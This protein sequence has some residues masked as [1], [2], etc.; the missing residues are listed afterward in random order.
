MLAV[1]AL[2]GCQADVDVGLDVEPDGSGQ[3]KATVRL[4]RAAAAQVPNL[5]GQ[6][7]VE[8][9]A[10]AGWRL[11]G[12]TRSDDGGAQVSAVKSFDSPAGAR[13]AVEE[14]AGP[15]GPLRDFAL[16]LRR[17]FLETRTE[18][19]GTVDLSS[20]LEGFG[21]EVLRNRLGGSSLGV[22]PAVLE[23]QLGARLA[24]VFGLE[25]TARLPGRGPATVKLELGER[26]Q[27]RASAHRWNT[28]RIAFAAV[29]VVS[30]LALVVVLVRRALS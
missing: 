4:D 14:L 6:L 10:A 18:L 27:L 12:P 3:V 26:A 29:A 16:A 25:V 28:E 5:A 15:R 30:S 17:S 13:R 22:D 11:E 23:R 2:S 8:D 20:G 24:D 7:R 9:L 1:A 21:D 19:S